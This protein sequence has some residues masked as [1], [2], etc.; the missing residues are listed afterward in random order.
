MNDEMTLIGKTT[1]SECSDLKNQFEM[2]V[3]LI[4]LL[5]PAVLDGLLGLERALQGKS[6][7]MR[8]HMLGCMGAALFVLI[9]HQSGISDSE[10]SRV[11]Q[12]V[13]AGIGSSARVPSSGT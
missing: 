11:I 2:P 6:A 13:I 1:A 5:L 4:R 10:M 3:L 8:T 9:P 7:G 12:G